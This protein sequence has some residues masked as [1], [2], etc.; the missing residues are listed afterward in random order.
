LGG[1]IR[2]GKILLLWSHGVA[3]AAVKTSHDRTVVM[4]GLIYFDTQ[5]TLYKS[6][7]CAKGQFM[8]KNHS[9]TVEMSKGIFITLTG[10]SLVLIRDFLLSVKKVM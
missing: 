4:Q 7:I 10:L 6:F 3:K 9:V 2:H 1:S 8:R 5:K